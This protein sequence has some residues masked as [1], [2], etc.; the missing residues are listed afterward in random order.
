MLVEKENFHL[1]RLNPHSS[2]Q[3]VELTD[4][5]TGAGLSLKAVHA[6]SRAPHRLVELDPKRPFRVVGTANQEA[7]FVRS[8]ILAKY[9][10]DAGK[11]QIIALRFAGEGVFPRDNDARHGLRAIVRSEVIIFARTDLEALLASVPEFALFCMKQSQRNSAITDE[12]LTSC[13]IRNATGRVAHLLCEIAVRQGS[14]RDHK[15]RLTNP[16]TQQ[17]IADM[18]GQTSVNVNRVINDLERQ[19][20]ISRDGHEILVCDWVELTR[21]SGFDPD[22]LV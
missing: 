16:F 9:K 12:W 11:R 10:E 5:L 18:T 20:L 22:Y 13:G 7:I 8:G 15:V 17:Q 6:V 19:G 2:Q 4:V 3:P 14:R 1:V 21:L